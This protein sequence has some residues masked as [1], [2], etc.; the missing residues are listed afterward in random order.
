MINYLLKYNEHLG[1]TRNVLQSVVFN[2]RNCKASQMHTAPP[3]NDLI[4]PKSTVNLENW[5]ANLNST[6][7]SLLLS[8]LLKHTESNLPCIL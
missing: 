4:L 2:E 5:V 8:T 7:Q 1:K 3:S 6:Q